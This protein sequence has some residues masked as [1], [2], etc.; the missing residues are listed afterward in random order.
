[1]K[2]GFTLIELLAIIV[3]L[4]IIALITTPIV[5]NVIQSSKEKAF[6]DTGYNL[7]SAAKNYQAVQN[8][9]NKELELTVDYT[10]NINIDK[11][12]LK[13]NLP[14]KGILTIDED[15]KTEFNLCSDSAKICIT[16][17][18]NSKKVTTNKTLTEETY[19][20]G[21][22]SWLDLVEGK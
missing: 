14:D 19:K 10:N 20:T 8:V 15:G 18:K 21:E 9:K 11:L 1:M 4:A 13:G 16:K 22:Q 12:S 17:T 2:R 6:I 7:I 3:I 5:L